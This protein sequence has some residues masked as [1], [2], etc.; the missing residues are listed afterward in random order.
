MSCVHIHIKGVVQG[1]GFRPF[2]YHLALKE[3]LKGFV[4]NTTNGVH[5][6]LGCSTNEAEAFVQKIITNPPPLATITSW[7]LHAV[8]DQHFSSFSIRESDD[9]AERDLQLTPDVALCP[10]CQKELHDPSNRRYHYPFITCTNCGP[11]YSI[12]QALPYDREHT[13]M[14]A[15]NM[16]PECQTEYTDPMDRRNYSQTNSCPKCKVSLTIWN[17]GVETP[18]DENL[19]A[20]IQ[21]WEEGE[22][23]GIKGIGGY[24]LTCDATNAA[25][26][27]RLRELKNRPSKPLALMYHDLYEL[28]EDTEIDIFE[29]LELES[30]AAPIVLLYLKEDRMTPIAVDE[31]AP[32][33][34]QLGVML[35]YTPLYDLLLKQ[36]KK[37][38]VATSG[39]RSH[40]AIIF[41]DQQAIRELTQISPVLLMNNRNIA[42]PQDDS[43]VRFSALKYQ[44]IVIR[45]AR[46]LAPAY[47]NPTLRLPK[48]NMLAMG[49]ML[50]S[51]FALICN[52]NI[53]ISPYLGNTDAFEAQL[54]YQY[55]LR[56][57]LELYQ[58]SPEVILLD[59]HPAYPTTQIGKEMAEQAKVPTFEIQHHKAHFCAVLAENDLLTIEDKIL[60]VIW[61]GTGLGDDGNIWG[62]EFFSYK[63]GNIERVGHVP[64]FDF[65][66]GDKM[67][68][69]PRI[70]ALAIAHKIPE[71]HALL[72]GKFNEQE[73]GIYQ[74]LLSKDDNLQSSSVGRIFDALACL[75]LGIDKHSFH[76]EA[77]MLLENA[78]HRYFHHNR[79][80]LYYSYLKNHNV[81]AI[82]ISEFLVQSVLEDLSKGYDLEFIAAK[83]HISLADYIKQTAESYG[84]KKVAFS[85]G[86]F[87]NAW[88]T[89]LLILFMGDDFDLYFHKELS[90]NDENIALGQLIYYVY[91][92][93]HS[94]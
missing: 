42:T 46:G 26:I 1:V 50:K 31:I 24:L 52:Q 48:Q 19:D 40:A 16:C 47:I 63:K 56:H 94:A 15:F 49:A 34:Q 64:Y 30:R 59:K 41:E 36:F 5:I 12:I 83:V 38:I 90:P 66:L 69:E 11:R 13:T 43:V 84:I 29:K 92:Q 75:I 25:A 14:D 9:Q 91:C 93:P 76:G 45:R 28:A 4:K 70:S 80:T 21:A 6:F 88:L 79:P 89:D 58:I 86:V 68:R 72:K 53:L 60:G 22:L 57:F 10:D 2:V 55:S 81:T 23:V 20:I 78:A 73:W 35:P 17:R 8:T 44:R 61:D 77:A 39:N 3:G 87:Q 7:S 33:L 71:A 27:R 37:P 18:G 54:N 65:I 32:G 85:G 82:N 62:G 74:K 67:P 51:A